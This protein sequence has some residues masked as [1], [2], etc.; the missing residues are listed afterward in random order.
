MNRLVFVSLR[1][2]MLQCKKKERVASY[3][4]TLS[5]LNERR[6]ATKSDSVDDTSTCLQETC[7]DQT[8]NDDDDDDDDACRPAAVSAAS[9][10]LRVTPARKRA[11]S[12]RD[13]LC[14]RS[15]AKSVR[16]AAG[17]NA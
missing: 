2:L 11:A 13:T 10:S 9:C 7:N 15:A 1:M 3:Q 14:S 6:T 16:L 12:S 4:S 17:N 5:R 8:A